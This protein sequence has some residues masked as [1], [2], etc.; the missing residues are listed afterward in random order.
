V[1]GERGRGRKKDV[2]VFLKLAA[3]TIIGLVWAVPSIAST[4]TVTISGVTGEIRVGEGPMFGHPSYQNIPPGAPFSLTYSFNEEMGQQS[5]SASSG[6]LITSS[7]IQNAVST[8]PGTNA[9]LRI[10]DALWEFGPAAHAEVTLNTAAGKQGE[11]IV[12]TTQARGNRVSAE[13]VPGKSGYW[14]KNGDWRASFVAT[15]LGGSTAS[16]SADNDRVSAKGSLVPESIM[17]AGVDLDGQWLQAVPAN[18]T[19]DRTW[20]LAHASPKGGY[21]IQEVTRTILRVVHGESAV[22]PSSVRY[23][24]AWQILPGADVPHDAT[25]SFS[26]PEQAGGSGED[27]VT[28]IARFYEGVK[29]PPSFAPGD[30]PYAGGRLSSLKDPD[31]STSSATLPVTEHVTLRF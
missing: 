5:L 14:P 17:V 1:P 12:F 13:I 19:G 20:Q 25:D 8:S 4:I 6:K 18:T 2:S 29:L 28:A 11:H 21:I 10:G 24:Q 26:L 15:S 7:S 23:W 27:N 22:T 31:L 9:V 30:S 3:V 16:F